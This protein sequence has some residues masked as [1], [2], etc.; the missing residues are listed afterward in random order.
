MSLP[1]SSIYTQMKVCNASP[2]VAYGRK[3]SL[4]QRYDPQVTLLLLILGKKFTFHQYH[5]LRF[6]AK[7]EQRKSIKPKESWS[8]KVRR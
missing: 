4:E 2:G 6:P 7:E 8:G 1:N 5:H 3:W